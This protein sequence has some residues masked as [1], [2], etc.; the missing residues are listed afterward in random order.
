MRDPASRASNARR[1]IVVGLAAA[2]LAA[3]A[4]YGPGDLR[5]GQPEA[6]VRARMGEP[7]G[8]YPLADGGS[9]LEYAR[10]PMG[11]HTY[12]IDVDAGGR[13]RG[14]EQV[15]TVASFDAIAIQAPQS[16]VRTRL[17][18]PAQVR[19]GWRGVGEVWSYRF[20]SEVCR[21]FQVW[22]VDGRVREAGYAIDPNC[23]EAPR[24]KD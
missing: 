20:E 22:F 24:D 18:R 13:V 9:K 5:P 19:V 10:G 8:R 17:G 7:T 23:D 3:C 12:M 16:E 14:W 6:D 2:A 1:V 4:G 11:K 15:M 21:W